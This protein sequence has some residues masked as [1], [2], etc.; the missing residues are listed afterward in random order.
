MEIIREFGEATF[1]SLKI[2]NY[3]LYFIGIGFSHVGNWMQTVALGWLVLELTGS[4]VALGSLLALRFAPMLLGGVFAGNLVDRLD[5]RSI[6][7]A[8]QAASA[9]LAAAMSVLVFTGVV[10]MWM[11]YAV[12]LGF[13]LVDVI[14]RPARQTFVHEMVGAEHLRNAVALNSTEANLARTLG[15]LFAGIL[16]ASAGIAFCFFTNMLS[17][18]VFVIFLALM[19]GGEFHREVHEGQKVD[20]VLAGLRYVASMPLLRTILISMAV[21]GTLSYEFQTSLP[22]FARTTFL[23]GAADYAALLSAM[24]AGSVAGGLFSASRKSI[25]AH[26]FVAWA[27]LFGI[28]ICMT[29]LMP[30]LGLA[31][32]SMVF[33]GFFSITMSSMANTIVQLESAAHMRGRVMSLWSMALFGSTLIGAPIIGFVGERISPRLALALGGVAAILAAVFAARRLLK[34]H[35]L[36]S[37]PAFISIRREESTIEDTKV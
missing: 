33:V 24:G 13:G 9:F 4:G 37:I 25:G 22:L 14:D 18:L 30:S 10:E 5:K 2:R 28:S 17:Y 15:P 21:I 35:E 29:S 26:E 23:G 34:V 20:H 36:L 12:A 11:V 32:V 8:T 7:Y 6:L 3:R 31:I 19:R 27:F 1:S 16:I